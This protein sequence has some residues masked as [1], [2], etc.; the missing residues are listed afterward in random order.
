[1]HN[2]LPNSKFVYVDVYNLVMKIIHNPAKYG[3]HL[4]VAET[5]RSVLKHDGYD[6]AGLD[7]TICIFLK[8]WI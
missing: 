1:M 6:Q 3:M 7:Y 2:L 5:S 4:H 8:T